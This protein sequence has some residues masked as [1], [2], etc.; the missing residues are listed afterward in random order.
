MNRITNT[1]TKD[2]SRKGK[3][4]I[5]KRTSVV[6]SVAGML[7]PS[8]SHMSESK[9]SNL[10]C[11]DDSDDFQ[12]DVFID[13]STLSNHSDA[14]LDCTIVP[15]AEVN[16]IGVGS[17]ELVSDDSDEGVLCPLSNAG[18]E[19]QEIIKGV[20][21][22]QIDVE[23]RSDSV[24]GV[25]VE[26]FEMTQTDYVKFEELC[27]CTCHFALVNSC[28][29]DTQESVFTTTSGDR[30]LG[31]NDD[32]ASE[33]MHG[34][35]REKVFGDSSVIGN[36]NTRIVGRKFSMQAVCEEGMQLAFVRDADNPKDSNA[37]KVRA[38]EW[39][40]LFLICLGLQVDDVNLHAFHAFC[41]FVIYNKSLIVLYLGKKYLPFL[42]YQERFSCIWKRNLT[43]SS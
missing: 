4:Q 41:T 42:M 14:A 37:V 8:A 29:G 25:E 34:T 15:L 28:C 38:T 7:P 31:A 13:V 24:R 22:P 21:K 5:G 32:E 16:G 11:I 23:D 27:I 26:P 40:L 19:K 35:V 12:Q 39:T 2:T 10:S 9:V 17:E 43:L 18:T 36:I 6:P 1:S 3:A 20:V 33:L 30:L